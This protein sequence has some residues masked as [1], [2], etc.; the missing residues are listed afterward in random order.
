MTDQELLD[1]L[2]KNNIVKVKLNGYRAIRSVFNADY[3]INE[4][5]NIKRR[6]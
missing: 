1:E 4:L 6:I 3:G 2:K 5:S